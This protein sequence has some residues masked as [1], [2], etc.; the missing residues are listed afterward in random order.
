MAWPLSASKHWQT[1][2]QQGDDLLLFCP[3]RADAVLAIVGEV[4]FPLLRGDDTVW[5]VAP[6]A[7]WL[8]SLVAKLAPTRMP[9]AVLDG[10]TS[11]RQAQYMAQRWQ[12]G[13]YVA[14]VMDDTWLPTWADTL[15]DHPADVMLAI[16]PEIPLDAAQLPC[17]QTL[18]LSPPRPASA[19]PALKH[20]WQVNVVG[21]LPIDPFAAVLHPH[22]VLAPAQINLL[23]D[24]LSY[25][26][27]TWW[28]SDHQPP[29]TGCVAEDVGWD[30]LP[31]VLGESSQVITPDAT[32]QQLLNLMTMGLPL[33]VHHWGTALDKRCGWQ[34]LMQHWQGASHPP[35]PPCGQCLTCRKPQK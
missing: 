12:A 4:L 25:R 15:Q 14:V 28:V 20:Q 30:R 35:V 1:L 31:F 11:A 7:R 27:P 2:W 3:W 19:V 9:F 22:P 24:R 18:W 26:G 5:L 29:P 33:Q 17:H 6:T 16:D 10:Q 32:P 23:A 13:D 34:Q 8:Q 21:T